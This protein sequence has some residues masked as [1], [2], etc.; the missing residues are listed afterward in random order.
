MCRTIPT[1]SMAIE[2]EKRRWKPFRNAPY[3]TSDRKDFDDMFDIPRVYTSACSASVQISRIHPILMSILLHEF[4]QI[5][6]CT[7]KVKKIEN[8]V[9]EIKEALER[10]ERLQNTTAAPSSTTT[11]ISRA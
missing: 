1:F 6:E 9:K 8:R 5:T 10:G 11:A 4:K 7:E 2:H 3:D